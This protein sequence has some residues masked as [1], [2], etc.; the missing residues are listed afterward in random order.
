[1]RGV[2]S[3]MGWQQIPDF[4]S[5]S[6]SLDDNPFPSSRTRKVSIKLMPDDWLCWKLEKLN[7]TIAKGYLSRNAETAGLLRDQFVKMPRT[8]PTR[9]TLVNH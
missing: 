2:R 7:I 8:T 4:D 5:S 9:G 1:M 3:F 6:S